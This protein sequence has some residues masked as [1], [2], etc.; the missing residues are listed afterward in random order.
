M[1]TP[2][3]FEAPEAKIFALK[4]GGGEIF[5]ICSRDLR[6]STHV[7][8]SGIRGLFVFLIDDATSVRFQKKV[9]H[10]PLCVPD[11]ILY[12]MK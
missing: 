4:W 10:S 6:V 5:F 12:I 1:L 8:K 7:H 2:D 11:I 3:P 9:T